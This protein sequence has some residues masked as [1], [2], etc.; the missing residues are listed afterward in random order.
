[1]IMDIV[2]NCFCD[3]MA[4]TPHIIRLCI[5]KANYYFLVTCRYNGILLGAEDDINF[6]VHGGPLLIEYFIVL[7]DDLTQEITPPSAMAAAKGTARQF[8]NYRH[9]LIAIIPESSVPVDLQ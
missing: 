1:M 9:R 6:P 4:T 7:I 2:L 8:P 3:L 5:K